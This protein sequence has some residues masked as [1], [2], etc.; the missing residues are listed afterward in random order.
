MSF[1]HMRHGILLL[2]ILLLAGCAATSGFISEQQAR[3]IALKASNSGHL[4]AVESP[5][6]I[7]AELLT[8][9][10]AR[11]RL[12][13]SGSTADERSPGMMVWLVTMEGTWTL[14]GGPPTP[15]GTS[16]APQVTF[17]RYAVILDAQTGQEISEK[18]TEQ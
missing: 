8:L 10:T 15:V 7:Q 1:D 2:G 6:N 17:H 12:A 18:A 14:S 5:A 13:Q 16:P 11:K 3:D 9:E 4:Q